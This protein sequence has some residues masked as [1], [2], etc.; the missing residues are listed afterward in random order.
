MILD[1]ILLSKIDIIGKDLLKRANIK[2]YPKNIDEMY[3]FLS[4]LK[5]SI[6]NNEFEGVLIGNI[7]FSFVSDKDIRDRNTTSRI[8]EDIFSA[9]F[10]KKSSDKSNRINPPSTYKIIALDKLC[11]NDDWKISTD[12]SGNKR[13]KADLILGEYKISL[14]TLKGPII[15]EKN[16]IYDSNYNKEVNVGSFSYRALLKGIL[17]DEEIRQLGDRK[18]GLGSGK[19]LRENVFNP[20]KKKSKQ[21]EFLQRLK[22]FLEYV[23]EEDIYIILKSHFRIDFYL[24]PNKSFINSLVKTYDNEETEFERIFYRWENNNLRLNWPNLLSKIEENKLPYYKIFINLNNSFNNKELTKFK[25]D[26]GDQIE[27]YINMYRSNN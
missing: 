18:S 15:N 27:S 19:Q 5:N 8:F 1:K 22:L 10:S 16:E 2:D 21:K 3:Q 14:K 9:L 17:T 20:I 13:E 23:Y 7:L 25:K 12:L 11:I 24:I 4:I 26:L 6:D